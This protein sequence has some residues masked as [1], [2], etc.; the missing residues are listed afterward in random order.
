MAHERL[1]RICFIDYDREMA[2]V[3]EHSDPQSGERSIL[4]V[5]RLSRLH[6]RNEAEFGMLVHDH[7][8]GQGLG[9]ELL[10]SL[11][12]IGQAEALKRISADILAENRTMQRLCEQLGFTLQRRQG[13]VRAYRDLY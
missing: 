8:Q 9:T 6:G 10:R 3:A 1:T 13:E 7:H 11:L 12:A 4:G 5:A 2:I